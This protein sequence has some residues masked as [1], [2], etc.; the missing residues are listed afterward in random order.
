MVRQAKGMLRDV[1]GSGSGA[2][3]GRKDTIELQGI[4]PVFEI[5]V[6]TEYNNSI[7]RLM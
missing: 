1:P 2:T 3:V 7:S 4:V 5:F 6:S